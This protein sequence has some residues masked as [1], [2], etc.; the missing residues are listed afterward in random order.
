MTVLRTAMNVTDHMTGGERN[1]LEETILLLNVEADDRSTVH[2]L[3]RRSPLVECIRALF[4]ELNPMEP[5]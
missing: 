3:R 2:R 1:I 4:P 5:L